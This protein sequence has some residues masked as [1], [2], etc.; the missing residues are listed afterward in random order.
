[1]FTSLSVEALKQ[2]GYARGIIQLAPIA[3][4]IIILLM[5][6]FADNKSDH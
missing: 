3:I 4:V 6:S 2:T 1:M 5:T